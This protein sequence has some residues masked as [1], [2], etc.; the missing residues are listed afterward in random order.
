MILGKNVFFV[1]LLDFLVVLV[2]Y[3]ECI[4]YFKEIGVKGYVWSM[5]I[6]GV[7]DRLVIR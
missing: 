4:L 5:L 6:S 3:L 7:V 1:M 2:Y